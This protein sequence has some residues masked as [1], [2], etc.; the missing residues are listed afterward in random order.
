MQFH[1]YPAR[2]P[3]SNQDPIRAELSGDRRCS[4]LGIE[5]N[6]YAPVFALARILIRAG[7]DPAR[8]IEVYRGAIL[9]FR[10]PLATAARLEVRDNHHG[11]PVFTP[12]HPRS[13]RPAS[14]AAPNDLPATCLVTPPQK[15]PSEGPP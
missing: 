3:A 14:T 11:R 5:V 6:T 13:T 12:W 8:P 9:C 1:P 2:T 15:T 4:A 10:V 7:V